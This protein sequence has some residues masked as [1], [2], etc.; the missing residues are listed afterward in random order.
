[1]TIGQVTDAI[2]LARSAAFTDSKKIARLRWGYRV[3]VKKAKTAFVC[4][5]LR[6]FACR[7]RLKGRLTTHG[8]MAECHLFIKS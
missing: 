1:M 7:F 5:L 4:P 8:I 6:I 3:E 2:S